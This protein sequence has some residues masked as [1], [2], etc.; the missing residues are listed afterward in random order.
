MMYVFK[1]W[2]S[3]PAVF[4]KHQMDNK[5]TLK[6]ETDWKHF[7]ELQGEPLMWLDVCKLS[8]NLKNDHLKAASHWH[9]ANS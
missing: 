1:T 3:E 6:R 8:L 4:K 2:K 7:F 9:T 5:E